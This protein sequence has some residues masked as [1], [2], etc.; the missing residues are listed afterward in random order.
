MKNNG[1]NEFKVNPE[2][3][4]KIKVINDKCVSA[5]TCIIHAPNTFD[6][7]ED[8]VAYVKEGTWDD[9]VSIITA[10]SSCPTTA[11]IV[12]DFEGNQLWPDFSVAEE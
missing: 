12:E 5:A 2:S 1:Q 3:K 9:A 6:L 10:A 7:D 4:V 8:G 11:I